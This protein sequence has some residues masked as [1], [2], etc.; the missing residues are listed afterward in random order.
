MSKPTEPPHPTERPR[1]APIEKL[2]RKY[3]RSD[4]LPPLQVRRPAAH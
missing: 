1:P 4:R 3:L 2:V